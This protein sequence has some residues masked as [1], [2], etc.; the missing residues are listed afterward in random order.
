M[1]FCSLLLLIQAQGLQSLR[2]GITQL[3]N[4]D[5]AAKFSD[6]DLHCLWDAGFKCLVDLRDARKEDLVAT[7]LLRARVSNLKPHEAGEHWQ[8]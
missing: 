3:R 4:P 6:A 2:A 7:G 8:A 5:T 1:C